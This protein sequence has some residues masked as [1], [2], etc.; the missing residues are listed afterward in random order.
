MKASG[1]LL[2]PD[3]R[4]NF[5]DRPVG[6]LIARIWPKINRDFLAASRQENA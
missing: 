6:Y 1:A 5:I 2:F 4:R 3:I